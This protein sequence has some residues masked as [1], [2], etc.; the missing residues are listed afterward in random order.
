[1]SVIATAA[2][3]VPFDVGVNVTLMLQLPLT[4][5]VEG[6][7]GQLLVW[8]KSPL[9]VPV[10]A[11][12]L[13]VKGAVPELVSVTVCGALVVPTDTLPKFRLVVDRLTRGAVPVPVRLT[14]WG[15]PLA[16]SLIDRVALRVPAAVGVKVTLMAQFA[17]AATLDPQVFVCEKSPGLVPPIAM[18]L[19]ANAP[20]PVFASVTV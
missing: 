19:I 16:L 6:L 7:S 13:M 10:I 14:V 5:R 12:P 17:P 3:L 15:L 11:T 18:L 4:P 1:M 9:L 20:V 2:V 8:A